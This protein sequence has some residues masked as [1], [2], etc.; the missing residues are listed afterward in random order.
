VDYRGTTAG[1]SA[2]AGGGDYRIGAASPAKGM[3]TGAVLSHD[4]AGVARPAAGDSAGA[5][6]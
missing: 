3:V 6:S 1:P 2:G 4:L 5:Y